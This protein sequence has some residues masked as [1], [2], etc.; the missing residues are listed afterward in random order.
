MGEPQTLQADYLV[1]G[2]G[3]M[4]MAFTDVLVTES[5]A[6]VI[7]V[8]RHDQPGGHWN[9]AY[10]FVRLHSASANYGVNSRALGEDAIDRSGLNRGFHERASAAEI[11]S[12]F[13][14][15]MRQQFLPTGRVQYFPRCEYRGDGVLVELMSGTEH[16]VFSRKV[17]DA[18][19]TDTVV[20]SRSKPQYSIAAGVQCVAPNALPNCDR[21]DSYVVIGAGKTGI[22]ACLWLLEHGAPEDSITWIVPRD[23]WLLDREHIEPRAA[24]FT[25]RMGAFVRQ[26]ELIEQAESVEHLFRLLS[27]DGQLLRID[28]EVVPTRYRCATVS[29]AELEQLRRIRNIVRLGRVKRIE[30]GRIVMNKG[31]IETIPGAL[32]IDCTAS[33]IRSRPA[34]PVFDGKTITLQPVRMCQ[35]CFSA[36]LIAHVELAY[37]D[38]AQ[39]NSFCKPIP[40]PIRDVDWLTMF[41]ANMRNQYLWSSTP[42]LRG[43]IAGSRLDPNYGRT[44][45]LT[46]EETALAQRFRSAIGPAV[47]KLEALLAQVLHEGSFST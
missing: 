42:D 3:A 5:Q 34:V 14:R 31:S 44:S 21:A 8:D 25:Q 38:D 26:T 10:P 23:S 16:R 33:G 15:I 22:D 47:A 12:Y 19:F 40:L 36:A 28:E 45:A 13:D 29:R 20:P 46:E 17:V 43:W 37:E 11:C 6:S 9:D 4:G 41:V 35:Q 24:F 30:S 1:V 32:H 7:M 39:K 27:A 2:A 18:T